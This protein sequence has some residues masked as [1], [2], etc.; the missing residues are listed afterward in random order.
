MLYK[1]YKIKISCK[2]FEQVNTIDNFWNYTTKFIEHNKLI[3]LGMNWNN[4][5]F[6]YVLGVIND[7]QTLEKLRKID[8][9]KSNINAEYIEINLPN[10]DSFKTF[11]GKDEDV[12]K[13]YEEEID[14]YNM[15]YDYELEYIDGKGNIEIKIH[16][17]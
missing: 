11:Y 5:Y 8:F 1:G 4:D 10:I 17:I 12:Q 15:K 9:N 13:I 7:E 14:C 16:Y 6:D 3:G 2:N